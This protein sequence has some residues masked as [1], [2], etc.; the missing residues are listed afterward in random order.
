MSLKSKFNNWRWKET[1]KG[2]IFDKVIFNLAF[3]LIILFLFSIVASYDFDFSLNMYYKCDQPRPCENPFYNASVSTSNILYKGKNITDICPY[4][5]CD[6]EF[7][8]PGFEHGKPP[9]LLFRLVW[10]VTL[11]LCI[12]A[13]V[14]NHYI[15]N[16]GY[17]I[18]WM[19][20]KQ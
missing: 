1:K 16:K 6:D 10:P 8:P 12:L 9:N 3:L 15:H 17:K 19:E 20:L 13:L 4:D 2:Y 5:W 11:L 7:L 14:F 18:E